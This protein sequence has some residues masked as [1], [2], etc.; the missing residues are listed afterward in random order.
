MKWLQVQEQ[1]TWCDNVDSNFVGKGGSGTS[2]KQQRPLCRA[3]W[4]S[5][6]IKTQGKGLL[7]DGR[8]KKQMR[9]TEAKEQGDGHRVL[10]FS[11][12]AADVA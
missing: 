10:A 2:Q 6:K 7:G 4:G 12:I 9:C 8:A 1:K 11:N 5:S 3:F